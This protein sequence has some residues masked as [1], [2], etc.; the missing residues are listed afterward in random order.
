MGGIFVFHHLA[1]KA[2]A[3]RQKLSDFVIVYLTI[4][5]SNKMPKFLSEFADR[6]S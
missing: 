1:V 4:R 5:V 2:K 3:E 6:V